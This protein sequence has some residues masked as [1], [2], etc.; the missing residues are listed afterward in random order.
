MEQIIAEITKRRDQEVMYYV[1][2]YFREELERCRDALEK[3]ESAEH[4]GKAK[5]CRQ[6]LQVFS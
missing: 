5:L 3:F 2:K 4:R 6:F 1:E